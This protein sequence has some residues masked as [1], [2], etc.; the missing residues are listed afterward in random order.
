[1][2]RLA[3][4]IV[5]LVSIIPARSFA[6]PLVLTD[7]SDS[8][9]VADDVEYFEDFSESLT[10]QDVVATSQWRP[11]ENKSMTFSPGKTPLWFRFSVENQASQEHWVLRFVSPLLDR[12]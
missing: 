6:G 11:L 5:F 7:Q 1:M 2:S 9:S 3:F 4:S 12:I 8:I 10:F